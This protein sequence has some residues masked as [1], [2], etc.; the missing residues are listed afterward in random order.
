MLIM[1]WNH[2]FRGSPS[3]YANKALQLEFNIKPCGS[4]SPSRT[5]ARSST[6]SLASSCPMAENTS[7]TSGA[8]SFPSIRKQ[9]CVSCRFVPGTVVQPGRV[10]GAV[11]PGVGVAL[12]Q[13]PGLGHDLPAG[14]A[15][16]HG[17]PGGPQ[18]HRALRWERR[19]VFGSEYRR[20][21]THPECLVCPLSQA[22]W[23]L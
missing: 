4:P 8:Q 5:C 6:R 7:P 11:L 13:G 18:V 23:R 19:S 3:G 15:G 22:S 20:I 9:D 2:T 12:P 1:P 17:G 16:Q 10:R 14:R 21:W